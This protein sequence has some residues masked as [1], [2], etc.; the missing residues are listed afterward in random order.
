MIGNQQQSVNPILQKL[1][2]FVNGPVFEFL[3]SIG[4]FVL[5]MKIREPLMPD[6]FH[7]TTCLA[8]DEAHFCW[9]MLLW[10]SY[11]C[12]LTLDSA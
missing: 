1:D 3:F 2:D 6:F 12:M 4:L 5:L 10:L 9:V 11:K 7:F 8:E